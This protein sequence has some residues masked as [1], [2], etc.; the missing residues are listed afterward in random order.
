MFQSLLQ[1]IV[2]LA[3]LF[4]TS[5]LLAA[6]EIGSPAP[7][8]SVKDINGNSVSLAEMRGN[9]VVLEWFNIGCPYVRKHYNNSDMQSLQKLFVDNKISWITI[10]STAESHQDFRNLEESKKLVAKL[11]INS[12]AFVLD[13]SGEIGRSFG[14]KTTPHLYI[15]DPKG[16]LVY[17]G[18]IDDMADVDSDPKSANNYLKAALKEIMEKKP[19]TAAE[20]KAYGCSIKYAQ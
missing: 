14:A 4:W 5:P 13:V 15:I 20:T 11:G 8:F 1:T 19:I 9:Y 16:T 6:V 12:S 10:N 18:A 2:S 17:Q 3:I 7:E